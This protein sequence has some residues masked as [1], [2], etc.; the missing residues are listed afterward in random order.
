MNAL[1]KCTFCSQVVIFL[2]VGLARDINHPFDVLIFPNFA[3]TASLCI[4]MYLFQYSFLAVYCF[5][6]QNY[7]STSISGLMFI[8][9]ISSQFNA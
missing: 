9:S 1:K 6:V 3:I 7:V 8:F 5:D 2:K 4:L